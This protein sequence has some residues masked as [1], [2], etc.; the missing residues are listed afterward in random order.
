MF[1]VP[2]LWALR[3]PPI[4]VAGMVAQSSAAIELIKRLAEHERSGLA[5]LKAAEGEGWVLL[6]GPEEMLPWVGE[7]TYVGWDHGLLTPTTIHPVPGAFLVRRAIERLT[8]ASAGSI[9]VALPGQIL[10]SPLISRAVDVPRLA[11]R[12]VTPP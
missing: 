3:E 5:E 10:T 9:M 8:S 4:P 1:D 11:A 7:V 2:L 6:I 12:M